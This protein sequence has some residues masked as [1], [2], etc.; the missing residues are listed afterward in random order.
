MPERARVALTAAS[1]NETYGLTFRRME[2]GSDRAR[3]QAWWNNLVR[4]GGWEPEGARVGPPP[5]EAI[6]SIA[7]L[8]KRTAK[9]VR[10]MIAADWY[11]VYPTPEIS[12]RVRQTPL[13]ALT[14]DDAKLVE[15][16]IRRLDGNS[17]K[18]VDAA[19]RGDRARICRRVDPR[20]RQPD[21]SPRACAARVA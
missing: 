21:S 1:L 17:S 14:E 5:P 20:R 7:K 8:F 4:Y 13:N 3:S 19:A 16:L 15:S 9:E 10:E 12:A 18:S 2:A 6:A 11:K